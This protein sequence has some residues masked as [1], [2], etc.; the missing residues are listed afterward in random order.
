MDRPAIAKLLR[1]HRLELRVEA[2]VANDIKAAHGMDAKLR[3]D[4]SGLN[5]I[6]EQEN[7]SLAEIG[8]LAVTA[9]IGTVATAGLGV[10]GLQHLLAAATTVVELAVAGPDIGLGIFVADVLVGVA[11]AAPVTG[12]VLPAGR[13]RDAADLL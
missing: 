1:L 8:L 10:P 12:I 4:A 2:P 13:P 9:E 11:H 7:G 3:V 5:L 6:G